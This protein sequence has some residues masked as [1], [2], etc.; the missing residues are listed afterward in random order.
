M[1]PQKDDYMTATYRLGQ[2]LTLQV[3]GLVNLSKLNAGLDTNSCTVNFAVSVMLFQ[4]SSLETVQSKY[5]YAIDL[6]VRSRLCVDA[7]GC[8]G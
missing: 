5:G 7:S 1:D 3:M 4:S 6:S 8:S 2:R